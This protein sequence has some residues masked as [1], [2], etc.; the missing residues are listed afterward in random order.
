[1][2]NK[3]KDTKIVENERRKG[4]DWVIKSIWAT[5]LVAW[6]SFILAM[7]WF[8]LARPEKLPGYAKY[9]KIED[10]YRL[11]WAEQWTEFLFWQLIICCAITL[12][13]MFI[14]LKRMKRKSDHFHYNL[15]VLLAVAVAAVLYV[16]TQIL[17]RF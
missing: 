15:A 14:N 13:A 3:Q 5:N 7:V 6:L 16:Y 12:I 1:M 8:R 10:E 2:R 4:A 11:E 9:K 17:P